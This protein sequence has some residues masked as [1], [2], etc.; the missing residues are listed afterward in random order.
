MQLLEDPGQH[1]KVELCFQGDFSCVQFIPSF[2]C[3]SLA[4]RKIRGPRNV[5]EVL[6]HGTTLKIDWL[7]RALHTV[8]E[9]HLVV[10]FISP[11]LL[12]SLAHALRSLSLL[13]GMYLSIVSL[14]A[15]KFRHI[16]V[17]NYDRAAFY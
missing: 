3:L 8:N 2:L 15:D 1:L 12:L 5:V 7:L 13:N 17:V 14:L 9:K 16:Q 4:S 6:L 10:I 11:E